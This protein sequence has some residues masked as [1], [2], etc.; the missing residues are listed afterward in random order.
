MEALCHTVRTHLSS[1]HGLS[2]LRLQNHLY[3]CYLLLEDIVQKNVTR[4]GTT[5]HR[6]NAMFDLN[7]QFAEIGL[8][9]GFA[10][11]TQLLLTPCPSDYQEAWVHIFTTL[12]SLEEVDA[13]EEKISDIIQEV[14]PAEESFFASTAETGTLPP[15][16]V[17]RALSLLLP[18]VACHGTGATVNANVTSVSTEPKKD[19]P[20]KPLSAALHSALPSALPSASPSALSASLLEKHKDNPKRTFACTRRKKLVPPKKLLATTRRSTKTTV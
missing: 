4:T 16:W 14:V 12:T 1:V 3:G 10:M 13:L 18:T 17:D 11:D 20:V 19:D 7:K 15:Q 2:S 9:Y 5:I 8:R 6:H